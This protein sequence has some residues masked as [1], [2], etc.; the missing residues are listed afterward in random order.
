MR[1]HTIAIA[2]TFTGTP[3]EES[4]LFW[5]QELGIESAIEFA[6]YNQVFQQ[7]LDPSSLLSNNRNGINV[8]LVRFEDWMKRED[9]TV[10][11]ASSLNA[12]ETIRR[13]VH[14][15]A[16]TLKSASERSPTPHLVCLCPPS[17]ITI[18]DPKLAASF[19]Q[20]EE[21]LTSELAEWSGV[22]VVTTGEIAAAYPV[23]SYEDFYANKLA[24]VPYTLVFFT[25]LGTIIARKMHSLLSAQYKAVVLDCDET[26][27]KGVCGEV[28]AEGV[29]IDSARK[30][31]QD[32]IVARH[33]SGMLICLC[34][35][36]NQEDVVKVFELHPEMPL[37]WEYIVSSRINW[38]PKS[39]NIT[40]LAEALGLGLDSFIFIDDD[41]VACAEV[42][43]N[44]PQVLTLQLRR[45]LSHLRR[46]LDHI[47]AF[48]CLKVTSEDLK[49]T[50]FYQ[51]NR[52]RERFRNESVSFESFLA[53]LELNIQISE[54]S[55]SQLARVSQ[56]TQRTNQ[57]NFN[58]IRRFAGDI[59][60]LC[61]S[62]QR[63]CLVV[64]VS[65]RFGDYGLVGAIIYESG[66]NAIK[67]DTFLLS[68]RALGRR[69]EHQMLA[70]LGK[71]ALERGIDRVDISYIANSRNQPAMDFLNCVGSD[72]KQS[73]DGGWLFKF[74]AEFVALAHKSRPSE[75]TRP[76]SASSKRSE[77][78]L[79][80]SPRT[81]R[82]RTKSELMNRIATELYD[83][84]HIL[85]EIRGR[86]RA[87]PKLKTLFKSPRTP[88]EKQIV[89]IWR[90]VLGVEQVG[91]DDNFFELG[92]HSLL[93]TQVNSRIYKV[94]QVELPLQI[95]FDALTVDEMGTA[96][97]T[98]LA[99][100]K[101]TAELAMI[102]ERV[103]QL[104]SDEV[105]ARLKAESVKLGP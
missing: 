102:L 50:A 66:A 32:F 36:N 13:N 1:K 30:A 65:D 19:R 59:Q 67:V 93:L 38:R 64:E 80:D 86:T 12:Y 101:D 17:A 82:K 88:V 7:L 91:I 28:G 25:S 49:R 63:E 51:Q 103:N 94:F 18:A 31:L 34:S 81:A 9:D 95:L 35:K 76:I 44:C 42:Q 3:V 29:E 68:C 55:S 78:L 27:W 75:T 90:T 70:K 54:M 48:D 23:S 105:E 99:E 43:A 84:E 8:I 85:K 60:A 74:P 14:D 87:R 52:E 39:E 71:I 10:E 62:E 6:P 11:P 73:I 46:F 15:F 97:A 20:M 56:L 21:L 53:S 61:Q 89:E 69:V 92:G 16:I 57:F 58:A 104:S 79:A 4:L 45:E 22:Y 96:I 100:Q 37:R 98:K 41:P 77:T 47:W 72:F 26:L 24:H 5:L 83:A 40:S 33:K 2:A